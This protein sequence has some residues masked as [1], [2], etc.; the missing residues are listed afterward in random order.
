MGGRP[1][2]YKKELCDIAENHLAEGYSKE[3]TAGLIGICKDTFYNWMKKHKPFS[4]AIKRGE[5]KGLAWYEKILRAK[6]S[7]Q[8]LK[9]FDPKKSDTSCLIFALKTRFHKVYGD[10]MKFE[11]E[12]PHMLLLKAMGK[13]E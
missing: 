1:T 5:A 4:D 12:S 3:A 8:D 6:M 10:R 11:D 9:N 13:I 2:K 7:G